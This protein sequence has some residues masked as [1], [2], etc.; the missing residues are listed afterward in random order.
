MKTTVSHS[1]APSRRYKPISTAPQQMLS[2]ASAY[3]IAENCVCSHL[4]SAGRAAARSFDDVFRPLALTSGQFAMMLT[5]HRAAPITVGELAER[6]AMDQSTATA[7][8][9]RLERRKLARSAPHKTDGRARLVALTAAGRVALAD[10]IELWAQANSLVTRGLSDSD[11]L[12]LCQ[13]LRQIST[14]HQT[15]GRLAR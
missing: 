6:L 15:K 7:N 4:Q 9:K 3:A 11:V 2:D 14:N 13:A 5:L 8:L 10:A 1:R 12:I